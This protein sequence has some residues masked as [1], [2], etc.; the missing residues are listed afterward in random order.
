MLLLPMFLRSTNR[1]KDGKNHRYF[2]IVEN[3]RLPG[4][5][6][7]QR[8]VLYLGEINDQQQAAWRKTLDV[9]DEDE[10]CYTSM[11]LFP[12]DRELP[13]DEL[14]NVQVKLSGL[15]LQRPRVFGNC[16]L[17][18]ELWQQ[19][20]LD[21]FWRHRLGETRGRVSWEKVL[22]LL[23]VNRLL[24]PGSEFR[25]HRQWFLNSAMDELLETDF[26]VAEKD[27]LYRCLDLVLKHKQE[28]FVWLKQK[29]ADLFHADF[30]VLLYDL[31]STYFEGEM[32]ENAKAKRGYSRD[33]RPDCLQLVIALV[34]T[35]DGFP[36]AYEVMDG[37]TSDRKTLPNFLKKIEATYGK[38]RRTWVMDRGVPTEAILK[39]MREPERQ[40]FYLVGTPRSRIS[41]HERKWVDLPW[42]KVRDSVE[43]KLYQHAGE[44]YVLAKSHG[45]QAKEIAMRRKRLVRLLRKLR[46]MRKSLPKRDQ[47]LLRIGAA[48]KEAGRAFGFVK[49]QLPTKDQ[50]VTRETFSFQ[51]DKVKLKASEQRDGHYLLR[52]NLTAEDPAVLWARYVQLTQI[53]SVFRS[54]KS[55]LGVRPIYHRLEHRADAHILIAFLAY[56]LQV[57]LKNRLMIHAP[58]LTPAAVLEKLATI[59]MVEVWIPMLDGRWLML[60][61]HTQPE[62]DVQ[63]I[64]DHIQITLP[65]QPPPRIKASQVPLASSPEAPEQPSL[66]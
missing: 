35:P 39:E 44:L 52:S 32:E 2:S 45:R 56:C 55:E 4:D 63:A 28:L 58:G 22:R 13:A 36:L 15:K 60:P 64:L 37:N 10:Q 17:A 16:W 20:G 18:C 12:E 27:R 43:G 46:A 33:K 11:S 48:K 49:I 5:K 21:E 19:L 66:W 1:K 26:A 59:Q 30:E 6:T 65:A 40:T 62:K 57:T 9:F 23:V 7:V 42:Q 3:R 38:A 8:T 14:D 29:W 50:E 54:L 25:L 51:V 53:E 47:L 61:R 41:E 31:T 24:E 34:V